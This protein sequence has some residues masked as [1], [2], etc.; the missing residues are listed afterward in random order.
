MMKTFKILFAIVVV[1]LIANGTSNAAV[2]VV[3]DFGTIHTTTALTGYSTTGAMMD[4]MQV[5]AFF[6]GGGSETLAWANTGPIS[7][8]VTGTGWSL[9]ESDDTFGG[10]WVLSASQGISRLL[11]DGAGGDPDRPADTL[12]DR[13]W[14]LGGDNP[15]PSTGTPGSARG[16]DFEVV[17]GTSYNILATYRDAIAIGAAAP[18]GD[19]FRFLDIEFRDVAFQ[20]DLVFIADTDNTEFAGDIDPIPAPGAILLGGIGVS[21]VGWLRRRRA[22]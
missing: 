9:T 3:S 15:G 5:T 6:A 4:L 1:L 10:H 19:I 17:G 20:G 16:W 2:T 22:M 12:F 11:L 18:V 7:G 14:P 13:A 21:L 8:G